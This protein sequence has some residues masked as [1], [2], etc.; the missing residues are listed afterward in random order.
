MSDL[1]R[2]S[3]RRDDRRRLSR[4]TSIPGRDIHRDLYKISARASPVQRAATI[5]HLPDLRGETAS[6]QRQPGG[7]RRHFVQQK[8]HRSQIFVETAPITRNFG[9]FLDLYG[10]FAGE[11]LAD[12]DDE[13]AIEGEEEIEEQRIQ[14]DEQ[15]CERRPLLGR[16][17]I[18]RAASKPGDATLTRTF[19]LLIKSFIGTGVLFLPKAFR[20]GGLLFSSITLVLVSL[21]SCIAFHL[22]LQCR[23]RYGGGY[24]DIAEALGGKRMKSITLA[25]ISLS[26][27]GFGRSTSVD[28]EVDAAS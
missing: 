26:Q 27:L 24:G 28:T 5:S 14:A 4:G 12:S 3:M 2:P 19:F 9:Q 23:A 18:S 15:E 1:D 21:I 17:K 8:L 20:N 16:R 10:S 6:D 25:S 22:L 11:D 13:N 7:F